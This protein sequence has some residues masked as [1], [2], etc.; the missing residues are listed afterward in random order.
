V[1]SQRRILDVDDD[2]Q[3]DAFNEECD[4]VCAKFDITRETEVV[5]IVQASE[6]LNLSVASVQ[7][8]MCT[9]V[10]DTQG[11]PRRVTLD[12]MVQYKL[13]DRFYTNRGPRQPSKR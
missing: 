7:R 9:G 4:A 2:A 12:A 8:Y 3:M 11:T 13:W 10:I 6:Y 5:S 1:K